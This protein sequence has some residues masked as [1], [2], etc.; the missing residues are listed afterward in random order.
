MA[1]LLEHLERGRLARPSLPGQD[2]EE[3]ER[4]LDIAQHE[5]QL[6]KVSKEIA[7]KKCEATVVS[8]A[9]TGASTG[10]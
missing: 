8:T 1:G 7:S 2:M 5:G 10:S 4:Q 9:S 3:R 6:M